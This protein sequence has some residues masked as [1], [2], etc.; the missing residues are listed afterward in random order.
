M[1]GARSSEF[2]KKKSQFVKIDRRSLRAIKDIIDVIQPQEETV[3]YM[4]SNDIIKKLYSLLGSR[5]AWNISYEVRNEA[6]VDM[7]DSLIKNKIIKQNDYYTIYNNSLRF[8]F[9]QE[10]YF[11]NKWFWLSLMV[12]KV[13]LNS[14]ILVIRSRYIENLILLSYPMSCLMKRV[15]IISYF[16]TLYFNSSSDRCPIRYIIQSGNNEIFYYLETEL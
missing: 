9:Y 16:L 6:A 7:L 5:A 2:E 4:N 12:T 10:K 15:W 8:E 13:K 11:S 14:P 3:I 1:K